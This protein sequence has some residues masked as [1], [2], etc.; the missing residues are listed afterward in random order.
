MYQWGMEEL[1]N[2][3]FNA[4][5]DSAANDSMQ[6]IQIASDADVDKLSIGVPGKLFV[7]LPYCPNNISYVEIPST[8]REGVISGAFS[9]CYM[10]KSLSSCRGKNYYYH[11][12]ASGSNND[13]KGVWNNM[14]DN[15]GN[16]KFN[17]ISKEVVL[18]NPYATMQ[19]I[20]E[21]MIAK[22]PTKLYHYP[23]YGIISDGKCYSLL[24][25]KIEYCKLKII[26]VEQCS[27]IIGGKIYFKDTGSGSCCTIL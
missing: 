10:A 14:I 1:I 3:T 22:D 5:Q 18:F 13:C 20:A 12:H 24:C 25:E 16:D 27:S 15:N 6:F 9:G 17:I 19:R 2:C 7:K 21:D 11:I 4:L 8:N 26:K 23:V